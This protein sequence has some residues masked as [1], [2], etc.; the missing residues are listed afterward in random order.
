[1]R[2]LLTNDDGVSS[3]GITLLAKSLKSSGHQVFILAPD[4]DRS[5]VSHAVSFI[6][7]P[8]KIS[9]LEEK[10]W[11]CSGTPVD[12]VSLALL[13]VIPEFSDRRPDLVIS[14][15]N[16]GANLGTDIVYSGTASAA[17]Q[18]S[19]IGIPA[20]ALSLVEGDRWN[21]ETAVSFSV[22]NLEQITAYWKADT[23]VNVNMPNG[24]DAPIGLIPTFPARRR[25]TDNVDLYTSPS[26]EIYSFAQGG[27]SSADDEAGSD[28]DAV[29]KNY[30]SISAIYI[31]PAALEEITANR[32]REQS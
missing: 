20:I 14:G 29:S 11:A 13:G 5:G 28:Y 10:T 8:C 3:V 9:K 27:K 6:H 4:S 16:R 24:T 23:F 1:M 19:L 12:C 2:I 31:Q 15:I 21:W 17:R 25:Y 7:T 26:G 30:A 18:A 32:G 22:S